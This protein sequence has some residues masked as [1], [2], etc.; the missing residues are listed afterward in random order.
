MLA[1][2]SASWSGCSTSTG[3]KPSYRA[4]RRQLVPHEDPVP[5]GCLRLGGHTS[6]HRW[7]GEIVEDR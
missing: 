2:I 3:K 6:D 7:I 5:A 4:A 1:T